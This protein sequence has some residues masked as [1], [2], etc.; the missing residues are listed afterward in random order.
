MHKLAGLGRHER[1]QSALGSQLQQMRTPADAESVVQMLSHHLLY[2][3]GLAIDDPITGPDWFDIA[4]RLN[5]TAMLSSRLAA[6]MTLLASLE[7]L[8]DAGI[9]EVIPK[10]PMF[11]HRLHTIVRL[12]LEDYIASGGTDPLGALP[13]LGGERVAD[14]GA[15]RFI[16]GQRLGDLGLTVAENLCAME[17]VD[18]QMDLYLPTRAHHEVLRII[19]RDVASVLEGAS[20][21]AGPKL[22]YLPTLLDVVLPS[23]TGP[24]LSAAEIIAIR[25]D[26]LFD[27]WRTALRR[28]LADVENRADRL[29]KDP[30]YAM[31]DVREALR[32]QA[33]KAEAAMTA[34]TFLG[35]LEKTKVNL[36]I[37][38]GVA[39]G[40]IAAGAELVAAAGVAGQL[41]GTVISWLQARESR[42]G[43]QAVLRHVALFADPG[44][45]R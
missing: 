10:L 19:V 8:I 33:S 21:Q 12:R 27:D 24:G 32:D 29:Q 2:T 20:S 4:R 36:S 45:G 1:V 3:H 9:V 40:L 34:S 31:T 35:Q 38:S 15:E 30:A 26:G 43:Q 7:P 39:I 11:D 6:A 37:G 22:E 13:E 41:V 44:N 14:S 17:A 5:D 42:A 18:Q 16:R 23:L 25:R 28:G